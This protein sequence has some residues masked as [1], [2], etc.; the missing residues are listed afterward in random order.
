MLVSDG[1]Q[2][3]SKS[4]NTAAVPELMGLTATVVSVDNTSHNYLC[5][6]CDQTFS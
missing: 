4:R 2:M 6:G 1:M 3:P 5:G